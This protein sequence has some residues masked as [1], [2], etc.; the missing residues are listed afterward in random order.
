MLP[1]LK[2]N[3]DYDFPPYIR[4]RRNARARRMSLRLDSSTRMFDLTV[5][6]RMPLWLAQDFVI[7]QEGWIAKQLAAMPKGIAFVDGAVLPI[8]GQ[9][10]RIVVEGWDKRKTDITLEDHTLRVRTNLDDPSPRIA[11]YLKALALKVMELL[12][13]AKAAQIDLTVEA[14]SIRDPKSRWGSCSSDARIMLSWRLILA[15]PT[16]MDY[17]IAHEVAHLKHLD[18]SKDFWRECRKL[19][20]D[21]IAGKNWLR[22]EGQSLM[23]YGAQP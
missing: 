8:L 5:P 6:K 22:T 12:A 1:F 11:R 16:A 13:H 15:P 10:R 20:D 19:S 9:D 23:R 21:Y 2:P 4:V 18:H 3:D 17:V 7:D 14:L